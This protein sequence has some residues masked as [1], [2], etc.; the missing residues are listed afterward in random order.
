MQLTTSEKYVPAIAIQA[1]VSNTGQIYI[2]DN[3][4]SATSCGI[5]LDSGD[6]QTISAA[7]LGMAHGQISVNDIW[8]DSS[9]S[10]DGVWCAYL[11]RK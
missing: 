7:A 9:V 8:L 1:E 5:E 6:S 3:Q 10:T 11:E 2:G 4:V